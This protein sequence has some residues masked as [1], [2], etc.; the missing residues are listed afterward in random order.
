MYKI[1]FSAL[2]NKKTILFTQN[3]SMYNCKCRPFMESGNGMRG[4]SEC[5]FGV[6]RFNFPL[7]SG[8]GFPYIC[9]DLI[10]SSKV[11]SQFVSILF[12]M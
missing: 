3:I 5:V 6:A 11:M 9:S 12:Y 8:I 1:H 10:T 2:R 4:M 7:I